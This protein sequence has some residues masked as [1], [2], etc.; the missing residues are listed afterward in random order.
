MFINGVLPVSSRLFGSARSSSNISISRETLLGCRWL[1]PWQPCKRQF[2]RFEPLE[3]GIGELL[4]TRKT[5]RSIFVWNRAMCSKVWNDCDCECSGTHNE[6]EN[7]VRIIAPLD[8]INPR[9]SLSSAV[10]VKYHS[11]FVR[12]LSKKTS[13]GKRS[14]V[15]T[16]WMSAPCCSKTA[17]LL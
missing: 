2:K 3:P 4:R 15:P 9:Q 17:R 8:K 10:I 1:D 7:G 13:K 16:G 12:Q 11:G 14:F 6:E 5:D